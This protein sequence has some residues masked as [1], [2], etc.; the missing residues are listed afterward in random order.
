L[1][2]I[3]FVLGAALLEM[4]FLL[5]I[6]LSFVQLLVI[7]ACKKYYR[8]KALASLIN[9]VV[10]NDTSVTASSINSIITIAV[11]SVPHEE[12]GHAPAAVAH[13]DMPT[14]EDNHLLY[15]QMLN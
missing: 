5:L 3:T 13:Q 9:S 1:Y 6:L 10:A 14:S 4:F 2:E 11:T 7:N 12:S 15:P 8:E